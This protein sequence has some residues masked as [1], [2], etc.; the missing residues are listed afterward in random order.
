MLLTAP[1]ALGQNMHRRIQAIL[2]LFAV[3]K[4]L[5]NLMHNVLT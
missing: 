5:L 2:G 4:H 3:S 1:R